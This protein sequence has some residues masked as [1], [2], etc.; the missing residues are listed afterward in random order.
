VRRPKSNKPLRKLLLGRRTSP[1]ERRDQPVEGQNW[2]SPRLKRLLRPRRSRFGR[3][4]CY[5]WDTTLVPCPSN[6]Y[7]NCWPSL[8]R[9]S[10][11]RGEALAVLPGLLPR[12]PRPLRVRLVPFTV[13]QRCDDP[14][15][16]RDRA[17][18][19]RFGSAFRISAAPLRSRAA[20]ILQQ[21]QIQPRYVICLDV[22]QPGTEFRAVGLAPRAWARHSQ[23]QLVPSQKHSRS[24]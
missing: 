18:V 22:R 16:H 7:R 15:N 24:R 1:A 6:S 13:S 21:A 14:T 20:E 11:L 12:T 9:R 3:G 23:V 8:T 5:L 19:P 17:L 4:D 2:S 10:P